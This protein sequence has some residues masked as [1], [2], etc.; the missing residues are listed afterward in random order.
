M[1]NVPYAYAIGSLMY[2][3][4]CTRL[5]IA[6]AMGVVSR[7]MSNPDTNMTGDI[8]GRKSTTGYV[9]TLGATTVSWVSKLQKIV[10]LSTIEAEYVVVTEANKKDYMVVVFL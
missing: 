2:V 3:M 9:Y 4:V 8:D 7:Y 5:D 1:D 6:H 10:A